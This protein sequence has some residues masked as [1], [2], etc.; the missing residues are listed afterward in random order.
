M[1]SQLVQDIKALDGAIAEDQRRVT[2]INGTIAHN[3]RKREAMAAS[4]TPEEK[5]ELDPPAEVP[6]APE[7]IAPV[8][9]SHVVNVDV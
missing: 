7:P 1:K 3:Q 5:S 9:A 2:E 8:D 4:L 6:V